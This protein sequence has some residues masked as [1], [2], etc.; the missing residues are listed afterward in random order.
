MLDQQ[1]KIIK[2]R[3][4]KNKHGE[5]SLHEVARSGDY[6]RLKELVEKG[7][8]VNQLDHGGW[9]PLSEA[10]TAGNMA[11]VRLL[12]MSGANTNTRSTEFLVDAEEN[13]IVPFTVIYKKTCWNLRQSLLIKTSSGLSPLMEAC[14]SGNIEIGS[15]SYYFEFDNIFF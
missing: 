8:D 4:N 12:L 15:I 9:T 14:S 3:S 5:S 11:N 6:Q 2:D 13:K 7:Y 10:V 1:E